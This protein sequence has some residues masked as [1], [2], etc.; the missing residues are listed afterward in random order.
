MHL[1]NTFL[2][3]L[4][5]AKAK[6][7]YA[8]DQ[9]SSFGLTEPEVMSGSARNLIYGGEEAD[10]DLYPWMVRIVHDYEYYDYDL[11]EYQTDSYTICSGVLIDESW[12]LTNAFCGD[13][14]NASVTAVLGVNASNP[15]AEVFEVER[16][17]PHE[18]F[19]W[20]TQE[21]NIGLLKLNGT[22][23]Y[24]PVS[25]DDGSF[26][27]SNETQVTALGLYSTK[28]N[29]SWSNFSYFESDV[30]YSVDLDLIENSLCNASLEDDDYFENFTLSEN[31]FC[32]AANDTKGTCYRDWG[33]PI[34]NPSNDKLVG[35]IG[36]GGCY[37]NGTLPEA[38]TRVDSYIDWIENVTGLTFTQTQ[39]SLEGY[40]LEYDGSIVNGTVDEFGMVLLKSWY[41][42]SSN[43][44]W[45]NVTFSDCN[46]S[47][48][49]FMDYMTSY[50]YFDYVDDDGQSIV[51]LKEVNA[52]MIGTYD[53][54]TAY[55]CER[56]EALSESGVVTRAVD[57]TFK[58]TANPDSG[59][60]TF[61][62]VANL[63]GEDE[64]LES[65]D[66]YPDAEI[67]VT[68]C[69][70]YPTLEQGQVLCLEF[71]VVPG[72][73]EAEALGVSD[74]SE[75]SVFLTDDPTFVYAPITANNGFNQDLVSV[76]CYDDGTC[77]VEM[78]I[79]E[80]IYRGFPDG[81]ETAP[82]TV[83]G[84]AIIGMLG[85]NDA[86]G[87]GFEISV[88][89]SMKNCDC[90]EEAGPLGIFSLVTKILKRN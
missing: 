22:S 29:W 4:L 48:P 27:A 67:D 47:F 44:W 42:A 76:N 10:N 70:Q 88:D 72:D 13:G 54:Y 71:R 31:E 62:E 37:S 65:I 40:Y 81:V 89:L 41:W 36:F 3:M 17:I 73:D 1:S 7:A 43:I 77:T 2:L 26:F 33:G 14:A 75:L 56:V 58:I 30:I 51:T 66:I 25:L 80:Q 59:S 34:M 46:G 12:V 49:K 6:G 85:K 63:Y 16:F 69:D 38:H 78:V 55:L 86:D 74:I 23:S 83:T 87:K 5:A 68:R 52:T 20:D 18:G 39:P 21:N 32:T 8:Q 82:L 15:D 53:N 84:R 60:F 11:K 45:A 79:V 35:I 19:I 61:G 9:D 90:D 50:Y 64:I 24:E 28:T 57:V